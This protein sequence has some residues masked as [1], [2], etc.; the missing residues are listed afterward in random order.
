MSDNSFDRADV[1]VIGA[2][3]AGLSAAVA[4]AEKI[5]ESEGSV[6]LIERAPERESGGNTKWTSAY[7]RLDDLYDTGENFVE[8][9]RAF[10][11]GQTSDAYVRELIEL[12]PETME[13]IQEKGARFRAQPTYFINAVRKRLQ[14]VGGGE[15]LLNVL[16]KAAATLGV[17]IAYGTT[18]T[19][20]R[21]NDANEI[22]GLEVSRDGRSWTIETPSVII[23]SGGFEGNPEWLDVE[24]GPGGKSLK[25]IAP[26]GEYNKGEGI[27]MAL[28]IGAARAGQWD[29]FHAEP[30]DPRSS[31][32]EALVMVFPYGILVNKH[33]ERFL[34][35]GRG[36]VDETYESVARAVWK[37]DDGIAYFVTDQQYLSVT[38]RDRGVLTGVR[39][40]TADSLDEIAKELGLSAEA[41]EATVAGFNAATHPGEFDWQVPDGLN[42]DGITPPK[43]NWAVP[44]LTPPFL[45]YPVTCSIVFTFGGL[46]TD[47]RARVIR[48]DQSVITGLYSAGECTGIYFNKYPGGTSVMRGM[49]FGRVAGIDAAA[50]ALSRRE[51][52]N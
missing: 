25:P 40:I 10:S 35:E 18:A 2:G 43:S 30:V 20:L 33:A 5:A 21:L 51:K 39:P 41:L 9:L 45:A 38:A 31:D 49:V 14:P 22:A 17:E 11:D 26:G 36:T 52:V 28:D 32:A 1:V 34:D 48:D 42:T 4:A 16:T 47:L 29:S 3:I 6:V 24:L 37:Q 7:F 23:A 15:A 13:W 46:G 12:L 50:H 44:L 19:K 8:D 27:S